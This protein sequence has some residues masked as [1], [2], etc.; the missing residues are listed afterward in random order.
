MGDD[1]GGL[2]SSCGKLAYYGCVGCDNKICSFCGYKSRCNK[3]NNYT[4][5]LHAKKCSNCSK[6]LCI[7]HCFI[8]I[9]CGKAYC[10]EHTGSACSKC[11]TQVFSIDND[12][13]V[14]HVKNG[15][16][17]GIGKQ[18]YPEG[19]VY[20]GEWQHDYRSGEG[21]YTYY[22]GGTIEGVWYKDKLYGCATFLWPSGY[23]TQ[24]EYEHGVLISEQPYYQ[25]D[26]EQRDTVKVIQLAQQLIESALQQQA[27][28]PKV[29]GDG[30]SAP[31][32]AILKTDQDLTHK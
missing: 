2:C 17:S 16:K 13:Y 26:V 18:I 21:K 6:P 28:I 7:G 9:Y 22:T 14:G 5:A 23:K 30:Q 27:V 3:C 32:T 15:L 19:S 29:Q 10:G 31:L 12:K 11:A 20:E 24:R 1:F 8:C 4:C 25:Q